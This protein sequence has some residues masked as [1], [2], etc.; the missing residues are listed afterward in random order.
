MASRTAATSGAQADRNTADIDLARV[1]AQVANDVVV[2]FKGRLAASEAMD[3]ARAS[4]A[5]AIESLQLN[6]TSI[7]RGAG[8]PGATRPIEVLQPVQALAQ[9]R[10]DYLGA[11]L[12]H[13]RCPVPPLPCDRPTAAPDRSDTAAGPDGR[14]AGTGRNREGSG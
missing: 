12:A 14:S 1:Q 7:R 2:S 3:D 8:L 4:V 13:N 11:V 6:L 10:T 5:E 9:A